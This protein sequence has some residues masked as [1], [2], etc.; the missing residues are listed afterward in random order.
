MIPF[1]CEPW[2]WSATTCAAFAY[3]VLWTW[4]RYTAENVE[5]AKQAMFRC[6]DRM[7][8]N[9]PEIANAISWES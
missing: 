6:Y 7:I 5:D 4:H 9:E 3:T 1:L 2:M 8:G